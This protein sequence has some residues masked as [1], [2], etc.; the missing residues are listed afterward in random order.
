ME[1]ANGWGYCYVK[2]CIVLD[3]KKKLIKY[4]GPN[5]GHKEPICAGFRRTEYNSGE[6]EGDCR[7]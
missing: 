7:Y 5:L 3:V 2:E 6:R 4:P 1:Q